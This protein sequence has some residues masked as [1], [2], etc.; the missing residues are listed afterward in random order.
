MTTR[1]RLVI[2]FSVALGASAS[3]AASSAFAQ[4]IPVTINYTFDIPVAKVTPN[5]CTGGFTLVSGTAHLAIAATTSTSG[6]RLGVKL[7]STGSGIDASSTGT[8]LVSGLA[9]Y[10]YDTE[11]GATTTFPYGVPEYFERTLTANDFLERDSPIE[12]ND[13]YTMNTTLRLIFSNGLPSVPVLDS[14]SVQCQ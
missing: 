4:T 2:A 13:S 10:L 6:F 7:A 14:I 12:T 11:V 1:S 9:Q 8:P 3:I 5:P